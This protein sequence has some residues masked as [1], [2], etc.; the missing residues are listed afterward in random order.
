MLFEGYPRESLIERPTSSS[1]SSSTRL[2]DIFIRIFRTHRVHRPRHTRQ[3]QSPPP[4]LRLPEG[5]ESFPVNFRRAGRESDAF[6]SSLEIDRSRCD[7][8]HSGV[9]SLSSFVPISP[10]LG[11]RRTAYRAFFLLI[12]PLPPP[13][14]V[15]FLYH[16]TL[17]PFP[18]P[19]RQSDLGSS[20]W[21]LAYFSPRQ[22]GRARGNRYIFWTTD[23]H[24]SRIIYY[25]Y[26]LYI[27]EI[28]C[29]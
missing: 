12:L 14:L 16:V 17:L 1:S 5:K 19:R 15:L 13:F 25:I 10:H 24:A 23:S 6:L 28:E 27:K 2:S 9:V 26:K 8:M 20:D 7:A 21:I 29:K 3:M 4:A 18:L 22:V 11:M